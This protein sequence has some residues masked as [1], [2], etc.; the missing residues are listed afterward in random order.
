M[1][2]LSFHVLAGTG[3]GR[4]RVEGTLP[5][6]VR[7]IPALLSCG[8][9]PPRAIMNEVLRRGSWDAGMSGG[10]QWT[11]FEI[12]DEEWDELASLLTTSDR[13]LAY[14]A[15]PSWVESFSDWHIWTMEHRH[16]VPASAHRELVREYDQLA[17]AARQA[18]A[19]GDDEQALER[20]VEACQAGN[21]LA[22]FLMKYLRR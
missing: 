6:L 17:D 21:R 14:V 15:P 4:T 1:R 10:C 19:S 12:D 3:D 20:H 16:G 2:P 7:E 18:R 8:L 11:P 5:Q 13:Q 22:E 9:V